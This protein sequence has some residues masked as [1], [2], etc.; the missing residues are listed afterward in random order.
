[1]SDSGK[2]AGIGCLLVMIA[3]YSILLVTSK[4]FFPIYRNKTGAMEPLIAPGDILITTRSGPAR[5]GDVIVHKYPM[6][7]KTVFVKRVIGLPG[8]TI[9]IRDKEL[10][11]NGRKLDEPYA[12]HVDPTVYPLNPALPEPYRSRDQFGPFTVP[13]NGFFV[14]GDNRDQSSDSRYWGTVPRDNVRGRV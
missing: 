11:L 12:T 9:L 1:M 2:R 7:P 6:D 4:V 5:R 14:L 10:F 3:G 13:P 8:D